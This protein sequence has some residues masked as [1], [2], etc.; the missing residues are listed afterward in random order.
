[1]YYKAVPMLLVDDVDEAL[2]WYQE[3]LDAELQYTLPQAPPYEWVSIL[4]ENVEIML[5]SKEAARGWYSDQVSTCEEPCNVAVYI[6][7][8]SVDSLHEK[9][10]YSVTVVMEPKDQSYGLREF[11][12]RDPFGFVLVFGGNIE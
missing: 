6:F 3:K 7:V 10:K 1:M 2:A 11:A 12:I 5:A 9:L 4:L 8:G